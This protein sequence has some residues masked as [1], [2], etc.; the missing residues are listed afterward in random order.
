MSVA[1]Q[2][3]EARGEDGS[4]WQWHQTFYVCEVKRGSHY[5]NYLRVAVTSSFEQVDRDVL[6]L[7]LFVFM[8]TN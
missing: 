2:R 4:G 8:V 5:K 7:F 1:N 6:K 3:E